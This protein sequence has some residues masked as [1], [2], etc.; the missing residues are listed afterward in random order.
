MSSCANKVVTLA[1]NLPT[2]IDNSTLTNLVY[3]AAFNPSASAQLQA[4][5]ELYQIAAQ[6]AWYVWLPWSHTVYWIEPYLKGFVNNP[7][8]GYYYNLMYYQPE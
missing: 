5:K 3:S 7:Y 4:D 1:C 8:I 2:Y 6:Q